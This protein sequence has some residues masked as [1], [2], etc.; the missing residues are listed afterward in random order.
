MDTNSE[1]D[2]RAEFDLWLINLKAERKS[3]QTIK[4]Y[5]D[6]IRAFFGFCTEHQLQV[7][8]D[9]H[10]VNAFTANLLDRRLEASTATSR[11]LAV[12][13]FSAWLADEGVIDTDQLVGMKSPKI[14][15]KVVEPLSDEQITDLLKACKGKDLRDKRDESIVRLMV[16]T[17][18]RAGEC[19]ELLLAD[20]DLKNGIAVV[21]RGKGGKGRVVPFSAQ[22]AQAIGRYLRTRR[23]H[24]LA[25]SP[26]LWLGDRGKEFHYDGLHKALRGRATKAGIKNFHPHLLR[27]TAAHRWLAAGGSEQGL[28]S[29]A[30]WETSE[31][32]QR[33]TRARAADRAVKEARE[34]NLGDL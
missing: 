32:L 25:N 21:R 10:T 1:I 11:Q 22:T 12:R 20:V 19:A 31:M 18:M 14:D 7:E 13:R 15:K 30:G 34:L 4:S 27:H 6:G 16:E 33:Y 17:G 2:Y 5:G 23:T 26:K 3:P 29:I 9:R 28:M 24:I 8:L